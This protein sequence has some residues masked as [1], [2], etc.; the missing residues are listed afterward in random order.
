[1]VP[2]P[3]PPQASALAD[4]FLSGLGAP[5]APGMGLGFGAGGGADGDSSSEDDEEGE[6]ALSKRA[7]KKQRKKELSEAAAIAE[8]PI[9]TGF[10]HKM[11]MKMGWGGTGEAL[12]EGGIAEPV[13]AAA[14]VGKRGLAADDDFEKA[15][16]QPPPPPLL[17]PPPPPPQ[18]KGDS[19]AGGPSASGTEEPLGIGDDTSKGVKRA[20][21]DKESLAS[22][23]SRSWCVEIELSAPADEATVRGTMLNF[24]NVLFVEAKPASQ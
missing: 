16:L 6:A 18:G 22:K 10:G 11:L 12:Q 15:A 9:E 24:P 20:R 13:K 17:P 7:A 21:K 4:D 23:T 5:G 19:K 14:P 3:P 2:P 1:M 8:K